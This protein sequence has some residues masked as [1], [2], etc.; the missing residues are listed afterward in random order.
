M[1]RH[2]MC[3]DVR[4][5]VD[6]DIWIATSDDITGMVVESRGIATFLIDVVDV[7][8]QL[9]ELRD[10]YDSSS[11]AN[12]SLRLSVSHLIGEDSTIQTPNRPSLRL[13]ELHLAAA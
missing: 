6:D 11:I 7:A 10:G 2:D 8:V 4:H 9:L 5:Y 12:T 1:Q 3:V 13:T